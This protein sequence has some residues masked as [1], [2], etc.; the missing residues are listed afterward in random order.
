MPTPLNNT[1][2]FTLGAF[3]LEGVVRAIG[4]MR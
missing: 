3:D 2:S 1:Q 4:R